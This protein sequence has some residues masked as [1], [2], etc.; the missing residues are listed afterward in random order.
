VSLIGFLGIICS[1]HCLILSHIVIGTSNLL[2]FIAIS[3]LTG[4]WIG[5]INVYRFIRLS[6][7]FT[8]FDENSTIEID[9]GNC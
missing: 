3:V 2:I 6:D 8:R 5:N 1:S 9:T 7:T 4:L